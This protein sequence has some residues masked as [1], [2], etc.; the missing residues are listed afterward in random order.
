MSY[1]LVAGVVLAVVLWGSGARQVLKRAQW[2]I[3]SGAFS[4]GVFA[5]AAFAAS[6]GGWIEALLLVVIGVLTALSSRWPRSARSPPAE[7][8]GGMSLEQA[9]AMLGVG[10]AASVQEIQAAYARL[11]RRAH[12]DQGG[13]TGLAT[14]LNI[15]RDRLLKG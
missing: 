8:G 1:L 9:R 11:M 5:A 7:T 10:P 2:R 4:V 12:P 3:A 14:Q 6:R 13:T 15:A